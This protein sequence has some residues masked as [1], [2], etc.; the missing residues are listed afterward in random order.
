MPT[1]RIPSVDAYLEQLPKW[2]PEV[3]KL[4]E[5]VNRS[6]LDEQIKW[7]APCYTLQGKN[8]LGLAAFQDYF[9]IWFYQGVFLKDAAEVLICVQRKTRGLRQWRFQSGQ[10][11]RVR[12]IQAYL[13]E[14]IEL[15]RQGIQI[16]PRMAAAVQ[17]PET[18]RIALAHDHRAAKAFA[19]LTPGRQREYAAFIGEA[20]REATKSKRLDKILPMIRQGTGLNDHYRS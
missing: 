13:R 5:I 20:V 1:R 18:L 4:R 19:A 9:G 17:L 7:G 2:R 8:V 15:A 11:I 14:A 16:E 12:L 10:Q 3:E 6:E